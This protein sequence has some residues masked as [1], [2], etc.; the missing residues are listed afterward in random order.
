MSIIENFEKMLA[1]GQDNAMLRY[2]LGNAYF[3]EKE[4][5]AAIIHLRK[6][7]EFDA[8]YSVAWKILGKALVANG[9][10]QEAIEVYRK[11]L[12]VASS[13]G[14]KQAEKEMQVFLKRLL[15]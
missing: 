7:L 6:A 1:Q 8:E 14:D 10:E 3:N 11:G 2:T 9:D 15:K 5:P 4:Y 13:K 12:E